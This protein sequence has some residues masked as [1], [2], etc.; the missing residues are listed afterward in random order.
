MDRTKAVGLTLTALA[1]LGS[2]CRTG[3]KRLVVGSKNFTEQVVLGEIVAQHLEH[4]LERKV[5]RQFNLSGTLITYQALQNGEYDR[6]VSA[7]IDRAQHF[8]RTKFAFLGL[9]KLDLAQEAEQSRAAM[10][11]MVSKFVLASLFP[12]LTRPLAFPR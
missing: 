9:A 12:S 11:K 4:R 7:F 6:Q 2:A 8:I 10:G 5:E 3:Q 1:L